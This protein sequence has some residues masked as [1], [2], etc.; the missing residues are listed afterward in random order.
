[1]PYQQDKPNS[2]VSQNEL[3]PRQRADIK[4]R[5]RRKSLV[6]LPSGYL[7]K[8]ESKIMDELYENV[9][10]EHGLSDIKK[11]FSIIEAAKLYNTIFSLENETDDQSWLKSVRFRLKDTLK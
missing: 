5:E 6:R 8:S 11:G 4:E 1:M 7:E 10:R 3:T 2:T 9:R